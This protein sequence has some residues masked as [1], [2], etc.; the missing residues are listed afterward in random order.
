[1]APWGIT[2]VDE[3]H[4]LPSYLGKQDGYIQIL[5]N[6]I[7]FKD[8]VKGKLWDLGILRGGFI[9]YRICVGH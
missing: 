1:M 7:W 4:S 5:E 6:I 8:V 3:I 9:E 2:E